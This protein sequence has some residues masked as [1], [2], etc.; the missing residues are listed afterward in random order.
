[1]PQTA[2]YPKRQYFFV[3]QPLPYSF[4]QTFLTHSLK[5]IH[6][7]PSFQ[8]SVCLS[9]TAVSSLPL[10]VAVHSKRLSS[11][12]KADAPGSAPI[13]MPISSCCNL[14]S[15]HVHYRSGGAW[16]NLSENTIYTGYANQT[17]TRESHGRHDRI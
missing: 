16:E 12:G 15:K 2:R 10:K 7:S 8:L 11:L 4:D 5:L 13:M 1:M 6:R 9:L 3:A 17:N 14:C